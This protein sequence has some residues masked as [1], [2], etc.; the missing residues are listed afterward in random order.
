MGGRV[1]DKREDAMEKAKLAPSILTADFTNLGE[2]IALLEGCPAVGFVHFDVMDGDFVPNISFGAP[3]VRSLAGKARLPFDIHLM[4]T[5]P[6]RYAADFVTENTEY[7]TVHAESATHLDRTLRLV[8]SL[9]VKCGAALN[10]ATPPEALDYVLDIVDQVLVMSVNPGFGGQSFIPA[11]LEKIRRLAGMREARGLD[12]KIG[13]DGGISRA[14][15][16]DAV[17]AGAEIIVTGSAIL[18]ARDPGAELR[19]FDELIGGG[20]E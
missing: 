7:I 5:E 20:M 15:V 19:A 18:D 10:P 17:E 1:F 12:F 6:G 2:T 11:S 8:R 14:N 13:V 4:V 9:G 16:L 3:V